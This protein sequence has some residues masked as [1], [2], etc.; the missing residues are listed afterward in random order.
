MDRRTGESA[1]SGG[2]TAGFVE[3]AFAARL[4]RTS[5]AALRRPPCPRP[6]VSPAVWMN[7]EARPALW[8]GAAA[9][10]R[11]AMAP[12]YMIS[13]ARFRGAAGFA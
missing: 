8:P 4:R 5:G 7:P 13:A 11:S 2:A 1:G 3:R 9:S 6:G 12:D 10:T